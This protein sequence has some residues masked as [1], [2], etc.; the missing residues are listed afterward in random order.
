MAQ[1]PRQLPS[2]KWQGIATHQSGR[3][4]TKTFRLKGQAQ[5]WADDTEAEWRAGT[6]RDPRA[7]SL[8]FEAWYATW[9]AARIVADPDRDARNHAKLL[10]PHWRTWPLDS[11]RRMDVLAWIAALHAA[12]HSPSE[13]ERAYYGLTGALRA[14]LL[15]TPALIAANPC[16]EIP[17]PAKPPP[18]D[19]V[20]SAAEMGAALGVLR[21]P[22]TTMVELAMWTGLR[23]GELA[24]L[25]QGEVLWT[26]NVVLV[27][28][29]RTTRDPS[30]SLKTA[31]SYR[32][33]P[34][35]AWV[36]EAMQ[37]LLDARPPAIA[38]ASGGRIFTDPAGAAL[39]YNTWHWN[40]KRACELAGF[41][42][43]SPH[44]LRH[45]AASWLTEEGVDQ[46]RVAALLGHASLKPT[47]R[48]SHLAPGAHVPYR[49]AWDK[50]A[51]DAQAAGSEIST[52]QTRT[53]PKRRKRPGA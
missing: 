19:R 23:F 8:T 39:K 42:Y 4:K 53:Q 46:Y 48:Y 11:I 3:R 32:E 21:E 14:A 49:E 18:P 26:R 10:L 34:V 15:Q 52:H 5:D 37:A 44:T 30:G 43:A 1:P 13:I 9:F 6:G 27:R 29:N 24:G 2:K 7:A 20:F 17:L 16:V 51:A 36:I 50:I 25:H 22:W 12:G 33:I 45:T 40:W 31:A 38:L 28:K 35:P 47:K 41:P